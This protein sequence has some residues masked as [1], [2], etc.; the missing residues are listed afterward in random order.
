MR[1]KRKKNDAQ[2]AALVARVN[3]LQIKFDLFLENSS[4]TQDPENHDKILKKYVREIT[5]LKKKIDE[6]SK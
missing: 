3:E 5:R 2:I 1:K 4:Q 6:L